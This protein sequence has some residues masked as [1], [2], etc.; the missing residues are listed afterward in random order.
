MEKILMKLELLESVKCELMNTH[1]YLMVFKGIKYEV[2]YKVL[3]DKIRHRLDE[4]N[5]L[6]TLIE[7]YEN[8]PQFIKKQKEKNV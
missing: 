5:S 3:T 6:D 2:T 7:L 4:P 8:I 1:S